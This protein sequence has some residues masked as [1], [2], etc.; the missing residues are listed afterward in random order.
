MCTRLSSIGSSSKVCFTVVG[1]CFKWI[2]RAYYLKDIQGRSFFLKQ[3]L[4]DNCGHSFSLTECLVMVMYLQNWGGQFSH[5]LLAAK[6]M[7]APGIP[8][9]EFHYQQVGFFKKHSVSFATGL[10]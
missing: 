5:S 9:A 6:L 10:L 2:K 1:S 8:G 4:Q 3:I 7:V